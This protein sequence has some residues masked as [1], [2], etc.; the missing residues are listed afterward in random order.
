LPDQRSIIVVTVPTGPDK[1]YIHSSGRIYRRVADASNP[2]YEKDRYTLDYLWQQGQR[3]REKLKSLLQEVPILSE[4][5]ENVCHFDIFL[6]PDPLEAS[7]QRSKLDFQTFAD[8][9]NAPDSL[10]VDIQYDNVFT[11]NRG[12]IT[13]HIGGNDPSAL[14]SC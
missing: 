6:L 9:M 8:F 1:P 2:E 4:A 13:R 5:E 12:Y 11:F 14:L 7:G 10:L 3:E